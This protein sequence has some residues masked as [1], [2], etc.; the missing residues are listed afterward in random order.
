MSDPTKGLLQGLL[1]QGYRVLE[2]RY[3]PHPT[4]CGGEETLDGFY[5]LCCRQGLNKC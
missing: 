3:Q 2:V 1:L 4:H 5:A